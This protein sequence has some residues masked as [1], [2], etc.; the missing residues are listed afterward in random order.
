MKPEDSANIANNQSLAIKISQFRSVA[1]DTG[2]VSE[3]NFLSIA[4]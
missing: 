1:N 4:N 3:T 2:F